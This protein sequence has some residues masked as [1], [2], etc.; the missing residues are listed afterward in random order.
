MFTICK[1]LLG[2]HLVNMNLIFCSKLQN[3]FMLLYILLLL[4]ESC[5]YLYESRIM[6]HNRAAWEKQGD[7]HKFLDKYVFIISISEHK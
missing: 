2:E 5:N 4:L 6:A 1:L 7:F 3:L